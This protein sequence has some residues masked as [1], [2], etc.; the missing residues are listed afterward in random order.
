[1]MLKE[2]EH[3]VGK[4][5]F[6]AFVKL[7]SDIGPDARTQ[8]ISVVIAAMLMYALDQLPCECED[9]SIGEALLSLSEEPYLAHQGSDEVD[10]LHNLIDTLCEKAGMQNRRETSKGSSYT[11]AENA[12]L[13]FTNWYTMPWEDYI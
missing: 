6:S 11:I 2:F 13:E 1:M 9:G 7:L 4:Q 12:I 10:R 3:I 5:M 8:R